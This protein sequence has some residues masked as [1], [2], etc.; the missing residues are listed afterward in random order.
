[1]KSEKKFELGVD[2]TFNVVSSFGNIC[3]FEEMKKI[4][5]CSF[6]LIDC[7]SQSLMSE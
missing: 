3:M 5:K 2:T 4:G 7:S 1:M 6:D